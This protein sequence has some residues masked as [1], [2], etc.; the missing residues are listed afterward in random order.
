MSLGFLMFKMLALVDADKI[1]IQSNWE[2]SHNHMTPGDVDSGKTCV[3]KVI[4]SQVRV[5]TNSV[6]LYLH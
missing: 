6:L 4:K 5:F 1:K 2:D 3:N